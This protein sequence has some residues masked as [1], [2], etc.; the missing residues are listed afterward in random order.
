MSPRRILVTGASGHLGNVLTRALLDGGDSVAALI[1]PGDAAPALEGLDVE[2]IEG[3]LRDAEAV[4]RAV[5]GRDVVCHLAGLVSITAGFE[6]LMHDVNVGGTMN[7]VAAVR[8]TGARLIHT[9]SIHALA[10][11]GPGE[12]LLE[13]AGFDETKAFG[14]YGRTKAEASRLVQAAARRGDIDASLVLPAGVTG[15]W[16]FRMSE[17][18]DVVSAIGQ[19]RRSTI[20]TGG[21]HWVDV[22]DVAQGTIAA[23]TRAR[24][25]E[26]YLLAERYLPVKALCAA[27]AKA[28]GVPPPR[29]VLPLGLA[30]A[31]SYPLLAWE[32]L[33]K[34][35]A[36]MTPYAMHTL[37]CRFTAPARKARDELGFA[38][39]PTE[40]SIADAWAW[41]STHPRSPMLARQAMRRGR[42]LGPG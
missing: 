42:Q 36:L 39:R 34:R 19:R 26:A 29:I 15:P 12:P 24:R 7:V 4:R 38:P 40:T 16:D 27:A 5:K 32:W 1:E 6:S 30:L 28:A 37:G 20:V 8:E 35:R 14:P 21:Y 2:R 3:D 33:T 18:G 9:S 25:G 10:E 11:V 41:L 23:I 22:R 31:V 17:I 13:D